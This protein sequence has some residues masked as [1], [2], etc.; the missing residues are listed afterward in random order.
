MTSPGDTLWEIQPH[1]MAKHRILRNYL[2]A[3]LPII[4]TWNG[5]AV[6]VDGFAGP[7][8]YSGGEDGSPLIALRAALEHARPIKA[9]VLFYFIED[10]SD[11]YEH[12]KHLLAA[13]FPRLPPN[14]VYYVRHAR[15]DETLTQVLDDLDRQEQTLAPTFAFLDPFGYS[16]TPFSIIKRIMQ[17][18][19][20]EVLINFNYEELNRFLSLESQ[21]SHFDEQFG[22]TNWRSCVAIPD[23]EQRR[24]CVHE[25]YKK[26]LE[27]VAGIRYAR[28]FEMINETNRTDYFLFFGTNSY[29]GLKKMKQ[30][31]WR[32]DPLGNFQF[33]DATWNPNQP[34]LFSL[35][36]D[37]SFLK[38]VLPAAFASSGAVA[39]EEVE[40]FVV[41]ETPFL[42]THY[43]RNVLSPLERAGNL[44]VVSSPRKRAF[45]YPPG[46]ILRF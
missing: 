36:P 19:K 39:V 46:T 2:N 9:Q 21:S 28:S 25:A 29:A 41:E 40:R 17:N 1:T 35:G 45:S 8:R 32:I 15:F 14:L 26:S 18:P 16:D 31:M 13:E 27:G 23:P 7:G 5:R 22:S 33:S 24:S 20:C 3:W 43:K 4:T 30:S 10:R 42:D 11:R 12:L 38:S 44:I 34:T 37:F 6:F